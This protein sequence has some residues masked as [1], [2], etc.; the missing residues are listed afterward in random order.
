MSDD[1][2]KG[3]AD[4]HEVAKIGHRLADAVAEEADKRGYEVRGYEDP[5]P[6]VGTALLLVTYPGM[7]LAILV[8]T[9]EELVRL[10]V[11]FDSSKDRPPLR[12]F[13]PVPNL[14]QELVTTNLPEAVKLVVAEIDRLVAA[15]R[16]QV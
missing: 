1:A 5:R 7:V 16:P 10:E 2:S 14:T 4:G 9:S 12:P 8:A 13:G 6:L 3:A 15:W 11:R